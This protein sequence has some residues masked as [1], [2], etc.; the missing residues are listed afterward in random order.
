MFPRIQLDRYHLYG[1]FPKLHFDG[2]ARLMENFLIT[3]P[4]RSFPSASFS[5]P[6]FIMPKRSQPPSLPIPLA[7]DPWQPFRNEASRNMIPLLNR[8]TAQATPPDALLRFF[9]EFDVPLVS[10]FCAPLP[11]VLF[12]DFF[13]RATTSITRMTPPHHLPPSSLFFRS[14]SSSARWRRSRC[15]CASAVTSSRRC[16]PKH[17]NLRYVSFLCRLSALLGPSY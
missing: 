3:S 17:H 2:S 5:L 15:Y 13:R 7:D 8:A 16:V 10:L 9:Q 6:T 4:P 1:D 12:A 14:W 11:R